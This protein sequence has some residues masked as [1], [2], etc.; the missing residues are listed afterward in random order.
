MEIERI[1]G[2]KFLAKI[3]NTYG[4]LLEE[5]EGKALN[6]IFHGVVKHAPFPVRIR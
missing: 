2:N 3:Y 4:L 6:D 1:W 5:D